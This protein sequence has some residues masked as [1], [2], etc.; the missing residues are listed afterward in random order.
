MRDKTESRDYG[1]YHI[2]APPR[3]WTII[4]TPITE[5]GDK[6]SHT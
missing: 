1:Y 2:E 4:Q 3:D 6:Y 5:N